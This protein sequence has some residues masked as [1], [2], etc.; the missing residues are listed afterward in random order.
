MEEWSKKPPSVFSIL[1]K[2]FRKR[3]LS[4]QGEILKGIENRRGNN[5]DPYLKK[6]K[7]YY[8]LN[9]ISSSEQ[10]YLYN[11]IY[12]SHIFFHIQYSSLFVIFINS[13]NNFGPNAKWQGYWYTHQFIFDPKI[14]SGK[15][16]GCSV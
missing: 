10:M 4:S 15:G 7:V 1:I 6:K 16:A 2:C 5:F 8:L 14:S 3:P 9:K 11:I 13:G 12:S